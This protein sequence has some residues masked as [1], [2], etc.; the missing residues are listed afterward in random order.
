M[1]TCTATGRAPEDSPCLHGSTGAQRA[2]LNTVSPGLGP[3]HVTYLPSFQPQLCAGWVN[4]KAWGPG[5]QSNCNGQ[6]T[7]AQAPRGQGLSLGAQQ[8]SCPSKP[9]GS[10]CPTPPTLGSWDSAPWDSGSRQELA[11]VPALGLRYTRQQALG[12][13]LPTSG[14]DAAWGRGRICRGGIVHR[15]L[16]GRHSGHRRGRQHRPPSDA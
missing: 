5:F 16:R 13:D 14:Q 9:S 1:Y 4:R 12:M 8:P 2:G 7:L 6:K 10:W 11:S 3:P 15:E